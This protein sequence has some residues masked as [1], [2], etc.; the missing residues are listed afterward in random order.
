MTTAQ[1]I[2]SWQRY[3]FNIVVKTAKRKRIVISDY[4]LEDIVQE[5]MLKALRFQHQYNSERAK[6]TTWLYAIANSIFCDFLRDKQKTPE[7][8]EIKEEVL[9]FEIEPY[10]DIFQQ[11][12][13]NIA[14]EELKKEISDLNNVFEI[15]LNDEKKT[16][17]YYKKI[18]K[19]R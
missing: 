14:L 19:A 1:E 15:I 5:V 8:L 11:N 12:I 3:V 13:R 7:F 9:T 17:K 6:I 4:D 2:A 16:S 10:L 18:Y